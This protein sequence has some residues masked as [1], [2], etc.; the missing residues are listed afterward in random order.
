VLL[1][2]SKISPD[3]DGYEDFLIVKFKLTGNS[4]IVSLSVFDEAGNFVRKLASNLYTGAETSISWDGTADDGSV[5]R[6][7]IYIILITLHDDT[8]KSKMWKKVCTVIRN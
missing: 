7:G 5:V 1:S 4:N 6:T 8:G 3:S 2:S